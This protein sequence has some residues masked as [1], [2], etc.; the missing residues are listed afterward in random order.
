MNLLR[1]VRVVGW[2]CC[3]NEP[4]GSVI[5]EEYFDH[6]SKYILAFRRDFDRIRVWAKY[7]R[8]MH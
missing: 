4:S 2:Y 7:C 3:G 1:K 8:G 6:L 5:G